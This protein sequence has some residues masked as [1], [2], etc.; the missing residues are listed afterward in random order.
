MQPFDKVFARDIMHSELIAAH[1]DQTLV[2]LRHLLIEEHIS[3]A[4]V[5]SDGRLVGIISRSDLVRVR[6]L[7]E[8]LDGAV[9]EAESWQDDQAD[10][11]KHSRP[12]DFSGF[13]KRVEQLRVRDAMRAQVVTCPPDKPVDELAA[14]MVRHHVH[15]IIVVENDRPVGIVSSLDIVALVANGKARLK[16]PRNGKESTAAGSKA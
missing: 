1:P 8:A 10:G 2:E 5:V 6:E 16:R 15:R 7:G 13:R 3:G 9:S 12:E 14:D 11:F 4:P